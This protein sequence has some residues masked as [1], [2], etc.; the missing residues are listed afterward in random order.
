MFLAILG[1]IAM[2]LMV[3]IGLIAGV[4]LSAFNTDMVPLGIPETLI[5]VIILVFVAIYFFPVFYLYR[6]SKHAGE[7]VRNVDKDHMQ[8][9]FRYLRKYYVFIGILTI[10]VLAFYLIAIIASGASLAFLKDMG[11]GV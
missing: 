9:A 4:F 3:I 7:A 2:G 6:F 11:S 1:F 5:V 8:K 10:A